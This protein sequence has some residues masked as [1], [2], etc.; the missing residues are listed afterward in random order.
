MRL[1]LNL[2]QHLVALSGMGGRVNGQAF[3]VAISCTTYK[4]P[5]HTKAKLPIWAAE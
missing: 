4:L 1:K 2:K 5:V 3:G